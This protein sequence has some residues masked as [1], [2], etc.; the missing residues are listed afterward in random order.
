VE[1]DLAKWLLMVG[2]ASGLFWLVRRLGESRSLSLPEAG[3]EDVIEVGSATPAVPL[4]GRELPLPFDV[5]RLLERYGET[6]I[7][8]LLNY[9][10]QETDLQ[11]GPA[12]PG[13]FYDE[14]FVELEDPAS[15]HRWTAGFYVTTPAGLARVMDEDRSDFLY[16]THTIIV[17]RYDIAV[18]LEAVFDFYAQAHGDVTHDDAP[19]TTDTP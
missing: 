13:A 5:R 7:P 19:P 14:L 2:A 1:N 15:G 3:V 6:L 8:R 4:V 18:I 12:D 17:R 16:G 11:T 10:F 9:Y